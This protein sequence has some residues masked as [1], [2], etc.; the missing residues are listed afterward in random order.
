MKM[1][2]FKIWGLVLFTVLC[3]NTE[4]MATDCTP[5]PDCTTLGYTKTESECTGANLVLKCPFNDS[6]VACSA[7]TVTYEPKVGYILYSDKTF[8]PNV[9]AGKIAI[10][11]IFDEVKRLAI[12]LDQTQKQWQV[13]TTFLK[14][15]DSL[16]SCMS[17]SGCP[18]YNG[19]TNTSK[20]IDYGKE[21]GISFPAAEYCF[22]YAP[23]SAY[24]MESWFDKGQWF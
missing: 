3:I 6:K 19:K 23:S 1:N 16:E 15:P 4:S 22:D 2:Y 11:V 5:T 20:I 10:G 8:S 18:S 13:G 9:E 12:A 24:K 21:K 17:T 7:V 14:V